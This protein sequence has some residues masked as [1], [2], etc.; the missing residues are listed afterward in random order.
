MQYRDGVIVNRGMSAFMRTYIPPVIIGLSFVFLL[1]ISWFKWGDA[2]VDTGRELYVPA[3]LAAGKVLYRDIFYLYGPL[4]PYV[5]AFLYKV[6][7]VRIL[8]L[9]LGGIAVTGCAAWLI[10]KISGIFLGIFHAGFIAMVFLFVFAFGYY[11]YFGIFNFIIPYSYGATQATL[12]ALAFL[13]FMCGYWKG[14]RLRDALLAGCSVFL[15]MACRIEMGCVLMVAAGIGAVVLTWGGGRESSGSMPVVRPL[16]LLP[17]LLSGCLYGLFFMLAGSEITHSNMMNIF[18]NNIDA[19]AAFMRATGGLDDVRGNLGAIGRALF[20]YAVLAGWFM[21]T[22]ALIARTKKFGNVGFRRIFMGAVGLA[23]AAGVFFYMRHW[24]DASL[25]YR[26]MPLILL[27]MAGYS[28]V[29]F[30]YHGK[31]INGIRDLILF[32]VGFFMLLR[33]LLAAEPSGYGFY[34]LVPG[35]FGYHIFFFKTLP[36]FIRNRT[37]RRTCRMGFVFVLALFCFECFAHSYSKYAKRTLEVESPAGNLFFNN[38]PQEQ[39]VADLVNFLSIGT[40]PDDGVVVFPEGLT[41]N[42]LAR[43]NNPLYYYSYLPFEFKRAGISDKI[44]R[45]LIANKIPYIVLINRPLG[46][47]GSKGFGIDYAQ[48][49]YGYI[50]KNYFPLTY[51]G[52]EPFKA[53]D[54]GY[55]LFKRR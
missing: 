7:G 37:I 16:I 23:G 1:V 11:R 29:R 55:I 32:L 35:L 4:S 12:F 34:L 25:Q 28:G 43:R 22:G 13:Y 27:F 44:I 41:V 49:V 30:L 31:E 24:F 20:S 47:Y 46:E 51:Y 48:E 39:S 8:S 50:I 19:G 42:V 52:P 26:C 40:S 18:R 21:L 17:L 3:Q 38:L 15:C 10:Y 2:I 9:V 6:F 5:N 45:E 36:G 53:N 14:R 54:F 33:I